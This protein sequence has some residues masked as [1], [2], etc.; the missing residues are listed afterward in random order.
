M[1]VRR[2]KVPTGYVLKTLK[3]NRPKGTSV[4]VKF[5]YGP[6]GLADLLEEPQ[7]WQNP[8]I[9]H[10]INL[11]DDKVDRKCRKH[12]Y[13][14]HPSKYLECAVD[15]NLDPCIQAAYQAASK[16]ITK[17]REIRM[18]AT[19]TMCDGKK[20]WRQCLHNIEGFVLDK[21]FSN[22]PTDIVYR[23]EKRYA[24][25]CM[26]EIAGCYKRLHRYF[27]F[28]DDNLIFGAMHP[29]I[30]LGSAMHTQDWKELKRLLRIRA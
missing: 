25:W 12:C 23:I 11:A 28:T 1:K 6:N 9:H 27:G 17:L 26:N 22:N 4:S 16:T 30:G 15:S 13:R 19:R 10:V 14:L 21:S 29:K 20:T 7:K 2:K 5:T 8:I 3:P 24:Q 18:Y